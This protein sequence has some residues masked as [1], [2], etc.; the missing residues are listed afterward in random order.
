MTITPDSTEPPGRSSTS[1][2]AASTAPSADEFAERFLSSTLATAETMSVYLGERLGWYQCLADHGPLT[3]DELATRTTTDPRYAREWLEMQAAFGILDADLSGTPTTFAISPGVAEVLTDSSSRSY[4]GALPRMFAASFGRL[5][6]LLD[7]YRTGGGV[8][9]EQLGADAREC[10]A[11]LNKPWF[12]TELA[13]AL[14]GGDH[15]HRRLSQPGAK[16]A[17]IGFG[18][19]HSTIALARAYPEAAFTGLDVDAASV[20]M[21]RDNAE[22][23]GLGERVQFHLAGGEEAAAHGPFDAAFAFECLHD[24]PRPVEVL[25]ATR[26]ALAPGAPMIVM[27]EA[28]S[29]EFS[30]P[31]DELDKLMYGFSL[32]VCLPDSMSSPPSVATGTVLRPA[33]LRAYAEQAGFRDVEVLPIED[34]AFF[35]FYELNP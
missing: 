18:A 8:S 32:F 16:I 6:E 29:D 20:Q 7:A 15:L 33:T 14:A 23:A 3:A 9:W 30:G 27:D 11:A 34:F 4:L 1:T 28:V 12:D 17:D 35:R 2:T 31:A 24:M 10:Q 19:G 22:A 21:A 5:P 13:P 25:A 26:Q